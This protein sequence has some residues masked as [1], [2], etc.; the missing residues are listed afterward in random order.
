M[1]QVPRRL[2]NCCDADKTEGPKLLCL[3]RDS[4]DVWARKE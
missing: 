2:G 3:L 1:P 4:S